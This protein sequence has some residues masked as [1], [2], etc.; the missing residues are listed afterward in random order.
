MITETPC[1]MLP[2]WRPLPL[3]LSLQAFVSSER[4]NGELLEQAQQ[5]AERVKTSSLMHRVSGLMPG[6]A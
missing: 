5:A 1:R 4:E 2:K 6:L 3:S